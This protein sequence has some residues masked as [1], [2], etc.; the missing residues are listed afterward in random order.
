MV[1]RHTVEL[2]LNFLISKVRYNARLV[3]IAVN[4]L[5]NI[6]IFFA[7]TPETLVEKNHVGL[8][9]LTQGMFGYSLL[10]PTQNLEFYDGA[11]D[12]LREFK[13]DLEGWHTET[14]PGVFEAALA[15]NTAM[16]SADRAVLF[17]TSV[18]QIALNHGFI[19]SF[20][21]KPW[22]DLPGCSGHIHFSLRDKDGNNVFVPKAGSGE[23]GMSDIMKQFVAGILLGL[24]SILAVL[25]PTINR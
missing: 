4:R 10:R 2:N 22:N 9:P 19:A 15:Y 23:N 12:L 11:Y 1:I 6:Q 14:G 17:K 5:L 24:P 20:M 8:T 25:A 18:K 13:I 16:E 21:A 3:C 7:E